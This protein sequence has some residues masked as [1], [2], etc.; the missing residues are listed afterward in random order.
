MESRDSR[1]EPICGDCLGILYVGGAA[2]FQCSIK[3]SWAWKNHN[4]I[5]PDKIASERVQVPC[6]AFKPAPRDVR[7]KMKE[8]VEVAI[9]TVYGGGS[10]QL[11]KDIREDFEIKDGD[12]IL[13]IRRGVRDYTFRK[14]GQTPSMKPQ[15]R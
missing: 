5:I 15:Y 2:Q 9:S 1:E 4:G 10:V 8:N 7:I 11:P 6:T 3:D 13:W 12:K 14:V